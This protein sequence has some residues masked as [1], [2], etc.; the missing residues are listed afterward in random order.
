IGEVSK[1]DVMEASI[2]R[3]KDE[4]L[5]VIL[6][7]NVDV[8][9]S[10]EIEAANRGVKIFRNPVLF[11]L[12]DEYIEWVDK[13]KSERERAEFE[14]L[15]KPGKIRIIEGMVFRRSNPAIVGVEVVG[16]L[17][18][19]RVSLMNEEGKI[20][21]TIMQIQ[22]MG[23]AVP[24]ATAGMKVAISMKEPIVGRHVKENEYL[25]VAIP[26]N[27]AR[28]LSTVFMN[29]LDEQS[30]KILDEVLNINRKIN[31]LWAR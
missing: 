6:A 29:K 24:V 11:R 2:V 3:E 25:Y 30:R 23:K 19:P 21:G 8:S 1:R 13:T 15:V 28:L 16:G 17:I 12:I 5:G 20:V 4:F 14:K 10:I 27:D 18:T 22:D 31:P 7:Y 9:K 26:E